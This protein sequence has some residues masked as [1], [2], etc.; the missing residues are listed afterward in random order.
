MKKDQ[1]K[2]LSYE[3]QI[4]SP[5]WQKRRLQILQRD[6]FTCQ[7]CGSTEKTL[8]VHHLYYDK[9]RMI[10]DYEDKAL[11]TLCENCHK[12]EHDPKGVIDSLDAIRRYGF[13]NYEIMALIDYVISSEI[14]HDFNTVC[15]LVKKY[16][17][18]EIFEK[19]SD[20][21]KNYQN[22]LI[23]DSYPAIKRLAKIR[24]KYIRKVLKACEGESLPF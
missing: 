21:E 4:K 12:E 19:E 10:W 7:I 8:H 17:E 14:R 23:Y 20:C 24:E 16:R 22:T 6:N 18:P 9:G 15:K 13:T 2:V 1:G 3:E 11:V 5:H